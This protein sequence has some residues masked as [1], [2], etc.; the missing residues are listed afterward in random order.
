MGAA[1]ERRETRQVMLAGTN[2]ERELGR[3]AGSDSKNNVPRAGEKRAWG[4]DRWQG[5]A[6]RSSER[7][8]S[9]C[10]R[11]ESGSEVTA[12]GRPD[13]RGMIGREADEDTYDFWMHVGGVQEDVERRGYGC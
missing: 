2:R 13:K 10:E 5:L 11:R 8:D 4:V 6:S 7:A 12:D 3:W 1:Q 9:H